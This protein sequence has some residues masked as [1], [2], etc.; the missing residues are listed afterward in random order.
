MCNQFQFDEL[1]DL[2]YMGF[3]IA[4][5]GEKVQIAGTTS[6]FTPSVVEYLHALV[7]LGMYDSMDSC[8]MLYLLW[9]IF[10]ANPPPLAK[11]C[12]SFGHPPVHN[13]RV[14]LEDCNS[15]PLLQPTS[16]TNC[17]QIRG[18]N[19][20]RIMESATQTRKESASWKR[21][22]EG[23]GIQTAEESSSQEKERSVSQIGLDKLFRHNFENNRCTKELRIIPRI[24]GSILQ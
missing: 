17:S 9:N 19:A 7:R 20:N 6:S 13:T 23:S 21:Q 11:C 1:N 16:T 24:I 15:T 12:S 14:I 5:S 22:P 2:G 18:K 10:T 8:Y 3:G 4:F